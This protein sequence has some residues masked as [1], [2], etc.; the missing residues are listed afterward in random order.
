MSRKVKVIA[1][2]SIEDVAGESFDA[3]ALP[4]RP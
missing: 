4:V 1:D 3:I 2:L